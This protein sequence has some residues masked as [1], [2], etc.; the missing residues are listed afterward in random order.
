MQWK[1]AATLLMKPVSRGQALI[2]QGQGNK[3]HRDVNW[4]TG[5]L[6]SGVRHPER[7]Q[8]PLPASIHLAAWIRLLGEGRGR[9]RRWEEPVEEKEKEQD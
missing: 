5:G 6:N 4:L 9:A 1:T 3:H 2:I 7:V 8:T